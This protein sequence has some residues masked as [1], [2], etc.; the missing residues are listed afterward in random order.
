MEFKDTWSLDN[1]RILHLG[2]RG[3]RKL[4]TGGQIGD[5]EM[6]RQVYSLEFG[7]RNGL[8]DNRLC[9]LRVVI[10]YRHKKITAAGNKSNIR[11][12][13]LTKIPGVVSEINMPLLPRSIKPPSSSPKQLQPRGSIGNPSM[14]LLAPVMSAV[15]FFMVS[16]PDLAIIEFWIFLSEPSLVRIP[17]SLGIRRLP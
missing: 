9:Q 12:A 15:L 7:V 4:Q 14:P 16:D 6:R 3:K 13:I 10:N 17:R 2:K 8:S 1:V 11:Q 5:W